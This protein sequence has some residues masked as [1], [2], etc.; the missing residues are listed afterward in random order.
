[1]IFAACCCVQTPLFCMGERQL[2][3]T[4]QKLVHQFPAFN[5]LLVGFLGGLSILVGLALAAR[6]LLGRLIVKHRPCVAQH[7]EL[8]GFPPRHLHDMRRK[9]RDFRNVDAETLVTWTVAN[10]AHRWVYKYVRLLVYNHIHTLINSFTYIYTHKPLFSF[11]DIIGQLRTGDTD[12]YVSMSVYN[13]VYI[14]IHSYV[15]ET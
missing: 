1:M 13:H 12:A 10:C 6:H 14:L 8:V 3:S 7:F 4:H 11:S 5:I 15:Y 2:R 9:P